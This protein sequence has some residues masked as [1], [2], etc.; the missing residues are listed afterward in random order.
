MP[1]DVRGPDG[2]IYR[3]NTDDETV[4][5]DTVR[6]VLAQQGPPRNMP[7]S[8]NPQGRRPGAQRVTPQTPYQQAFAR[9]AARRPLARGRPSDPLPDAM[10]PVAEGLR[11]VNSALE[12]TEQWPNVLGIGDEMRGASAYV[13]Q[14]AENLLRRAQGRQI[15]IPAAVAGQAAADEELANYDR[16]RRDRPGQNALAT[17][18]AGIAGAGRPVTTTRPLTMLQAGTGAAAINAPFAL[19]RQEGTLQ[20]R[21]PGAAAET[22]MMFGFGAGLTG[23]AN[24]L[25]RPRI[26]PAAQQR[27]AEF[28]AAGVRALLAAVQGRGAAP[29]AMGIAEN[30]MIGG[31]ARLHLQDSVDDVAAA[32]GRLT[33]RAGTP[34]TSREIAGE[35]L[36]RGVQRFANDRNVPQPAPGPAS[37]VPSR[38]WSFAAKARSLYDDVFARL[39][40]EEQA[41]VGQVDGPLIDTAATQRALDDIISEVS[42]PASR[43]VL[44]PPM[45]RTIQSA[46][47]DDM[48]AGALRFN[49]LRRWRTWAREAQRDEGLRQ[50]IS[51]AALRRLEGALSEDIYA[52]ARLLGGQA[53]NDLRAV[54]RWYRRVNERI[55]SALEPF[56]AGP[57]NGGAQAY[58]RIIQLAQQGSLAN[59][60]EL[61]RVRAALRPDEWRTVTA[62]IMDEMGHPSFGA[63][64]ALER[65]AFSLEHFVS[66][67]ARMSDEGRNLLFGREL[68]GALEQLGRV[69]GYI[70]GVRG[71]ANY[72][73]S[74]S[75]I[76]NMST[77]GLIGG[78]AVSAGTGNLVP[79]AAL[80][81]S[82][83]AARVT[84]EMLTNPAFVRWLTSSGG[85]S[86]QLGALATLAARDPA[87]APLYTELVQLADNRSRAPASLPREPAEQ[88]P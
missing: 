4:A 50:G 16:F 85:L 14:G 65:G 62:T 23:A 31:S 64:N 66:N 52:S 19:A 55:I 46:M 75:S 76:Q 21:L 54:D 80:V 43:D 28:D 56:A 61:G 33:E 11:S 67:A 51:N 60:R 86:R 87:L 83:L 35:I 77:F 40:R 8:S 24:H 25:L 12:F 3:V 20:E 84:G 45:I 36:Q 53:A 81:A 13:G 37:Q 88:S 17:G 7:R 18:M 34:E 68:A 22:A 2:T 38:S 26:A 6:R 49:D 71:F 29:M 47:A 10:R 58:R 79:L 73:R 39:A 63:A 1:I 72:S 69:A 57:G 78:A 27:M 74:G 15:E 44:T 59:V 70:K 32:A 48:A 5:R 30:P 82:G 41:M 42:G 9:E